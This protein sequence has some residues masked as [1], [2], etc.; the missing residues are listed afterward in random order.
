[1]DTFGKRQSSINELKAVYTTADNR[2]NVN[3][4]GTV[5]PTGHSWSIEKKGGRK[6]K[7]RQISK[8]KRKW[9]EGTRLEEE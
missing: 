4:C 2:N 7:E 9:Q 6:S 5:S 1:M 8:R 3:I